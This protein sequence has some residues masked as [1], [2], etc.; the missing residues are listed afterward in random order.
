M[1]NLVE[2]GRSYAERLPLPRDLKELRAAHGKGQSRHSHAS[3]FGVTAWSRVEL[4]KR[5]RCPSPGSNSFVSF[6]GLSHVARFEE[7]ILWVA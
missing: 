7:A 6:A 4:P 1:W 5:N 2:D 3:S